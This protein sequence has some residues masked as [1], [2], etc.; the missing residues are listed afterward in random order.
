M[1]SFTA[2]QPCIP[3][4]T[5]HMAGHK[6]A[7]LHLFHMLCLLKPKHW[8]CW[9]RNQSHQNIVLTAWRTLCNSTR[10]SCFQAH[11]RQVTSVRKAFFFSSRGTTQLSCCFSHYRMR[12]GQL[13][14]AV[15]CFF[16][17]LQLPTTNRRIINVCVN[18]A[19]NR[20]PCSFPGP[21]KIPLNSSI[22]NTT[23][24][25]FAFSNK[26]HEAVTELSP[27]PQ[28][29]SSHSLLGLAVTIPTVCCLYLLQLLLQLFFCS[30]DLLWLLVLWNREMSIALLFSL[31]SKQTNWSEAVSSRVSISTALAG[32]KLHSW[33]LLTRE[34]FPLSATS[35][36]GLERWCPPGRDICQDL[37]CQLKC[38]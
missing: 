27:I 5:L 34:V 10:G 33:A 22:N 25:Y 16:C 21:A 28:H 19:K 1:S 14:A 37:E 15:T 36:V 9:Q 29:L 31:C 30:Q 13:T 26:N 17:L 18:K 6:E 35:N 38:K 23:C 8:S 20:L 3:H 2:Q 12:K 11:S 32:C 24:I 7:A 4:V